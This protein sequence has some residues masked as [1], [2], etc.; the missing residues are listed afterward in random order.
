MEHK[1]GK[2]S[3]KQVFHQFAKAA[4]PVQSPLGSAS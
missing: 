3:S 4:S 2:I 1:K